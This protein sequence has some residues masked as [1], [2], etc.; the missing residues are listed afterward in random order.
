MLYAAQAE[1]MHRLLLFRFGE[2]LRAGG[3]ITTIFEAWCSD[4]HAIA[5]GDVGDAVAS[6]Y[7]AARDGPPGGQFCRS[8]SGE[9]QKPLL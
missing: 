6:F 9:A 8:E 2:A 7:V 4:Q 3:K 1:S 5:C